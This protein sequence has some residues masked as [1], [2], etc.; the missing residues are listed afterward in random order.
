MYMG[1]SRKGEASK[2]IGLRATRVTRM[3]R[4]HFI[5]STMGAL[6]ATH[7]AG[8][9]TARSSSNRSYR[10]AVI[11]HTGLG[12]YGHG[13]DVA[14]NPF[15]SIEVVAV[16][17]P[18]DVGRQEAMGRTNAKK[19][20]RDYR[21]MLKLEHPDL[22]A[23]C[24]HA[25]DHRLEMVTAA[26]EAGAHILMEKPFSS[27]LVEAD[28]MV[29]AVQ[30]HGVKVQVGLVTATLPS[31]Q[32]VLHMIQEGEIGVL[33]EIRAR[34]KEDRRAGGEDLMTLGVH[35]MH[36]TRMFA[37]DPRWAF[38]HVTRDG[39]EI[40][41]SHVHTERRGSGSMGL[42]AGNQ[43]AAM[44]ALERGV[45]AYF[46]SKTSDVQTGKRFGLY[47][48]G[49][50]GVLYLP[51][52]GDSSI[53]RSPDWHSNSWQTLEPPAGEQVSM[54]DLATFMV[55]DLVRAIEKDGKPAVNEED[56]RW[57]I[58]MISSV[59]QSQKTGARVTFPLHDRGHPLAKL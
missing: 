52:I 39:A 10:A 8:S 23:I 46:G 51:T 50:K 34:G 13:W 38:A 24:P 37:G 15:D 16:A 11:G 43:I 17:D 29:S 53:L 12:N 54:D 21:K 40:E 31:T 56:G 18:D 1:S 30:K 47:F 4:R 22:V 25:L 59:Y 27:S 26:A 57:T 14:F 45:H 2:K 5:K 49:T 20:Y 32:R 41:P 48:Y 28:A 6:A 3:Y 55:A 33:Q 36:L 58:E 44:F 7:A 42:M 9:L 35:L 19:G